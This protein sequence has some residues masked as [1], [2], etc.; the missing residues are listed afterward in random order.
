[1]KITHLK[2]IDVDN[3]GRVVAPIQA[4]TRNERLET[5]IVFGI[6]DLRALVSAIQHYYLFKTNRSSRQEEIADLAFKMERLLSKEKSVD[7]R[8]WSPVKLSIPEEED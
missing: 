2:S 8:I 1:M 3:F 7:G 4:D 6:K 5:Y